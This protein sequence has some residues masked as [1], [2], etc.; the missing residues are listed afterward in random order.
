LNSLHCNSQETASNHTL[1]V[2][3]KMTQYSRLKEL[4]QH[5]PI[6]PKQDNERSYHGLTLS[7]PYFWLKDQEYPTVNDSEVLDYLKAENAYHAQF[8]E[9]HK[10][11]VDTVFEEFKGRTDETEESVP[12]VDNGYQYHWFYREGEEYRTRSRKNLSTGEEAVFLDQNQL[13]QGHEYYVLGDWQISPDNRYLAYSF[14]TAGDERYQ[15]AVIDL[16][17][18]EPLSDVLQ[19]VEGGI[20]FSADS[21]SIVYAL[22]EKERWHAKHLMAHRLGTKQSQDR[23]LYM[24]EDDGFSIG[25]AAGSGV[26]S[27]GAV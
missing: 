25:F 20:I 27:G 13:A 1:Q 24:E 6:A 11:L 17:T 10:S 9:P 26:P 3:E 23:T 5:A 4:A 15:V 16:Q 19:D 7:D 14:D 8:L 12:Y 21:Q 18:G 2:S 22:L